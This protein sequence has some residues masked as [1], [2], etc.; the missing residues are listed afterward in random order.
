MTQSTYKG[1]PIY[2]YAGDSR[3]GDTNG[4]NFEVWYVI[5]DPF[6]SAVAMTRAGGP[7]IPLHPFFGSSREFVFKLS[8]RIGK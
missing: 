5:K 3:A 4:D 7:G 2:F 6:Y 1:W 8:G